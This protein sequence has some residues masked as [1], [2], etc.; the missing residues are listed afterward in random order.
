MR[1]T[2]KWMD[3]PETEYRASRLCRVLANP[4]TYAILKV[5]AKRKFAT[6]S[7]FVRILKRTKSTISDHLRNLRNLD[8]I[9]YQRRGREVVYWLKSVRILDVFN[10]LEKYIQAVRRMY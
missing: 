7:D 9:S 6:P 5:L 2:G 8:L 1:A 10:A 4:K 3:M